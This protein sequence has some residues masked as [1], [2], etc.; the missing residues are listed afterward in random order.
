MKETVWYVTLMVI[1]AAAMI[2]AG[3]ENS[4]KPTEKC[5]IM[6]RG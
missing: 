1:F 6:E 3:M 5:Y 4:C 2:S